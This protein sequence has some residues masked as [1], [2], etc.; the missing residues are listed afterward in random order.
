[1]S[2]TPSFFDQGYELHHENPELML[3][4]VYRLVANLPHQHAQEFVEGY[5]AARA[6]REEAQA[7]SDFNE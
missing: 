3:S 5:K 6:Q 2:D 4:Q 7:E 1:M